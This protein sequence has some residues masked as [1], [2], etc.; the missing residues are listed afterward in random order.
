MSDSTPKA[1][2][3]GIVKLGDFALKVHLL[4]GGSTVVEEESMLDFLKWLGS[5]SHPLFSAKEVSE[6]VDTAL[7]KIDDWESID[8]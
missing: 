4:E 8:E 3:S 6:F 5:A 1:V 7:N 2:Y